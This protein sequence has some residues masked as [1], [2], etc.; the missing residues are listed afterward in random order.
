MLA[1][2]AVAY[3][4]CTDRNKIYTQMSRDESEIA[5]KSFVL[6]QIMSAQCMLFG[7]ARDGHK[8]ENTSFMRNAHAPVNLFAYVFA[9]LA[10]PAECAISVNPKRQQWAPIIF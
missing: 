8:T 9:S 2:A 7:I 5:E 4:D 10:R 6:S 1:A 3:G